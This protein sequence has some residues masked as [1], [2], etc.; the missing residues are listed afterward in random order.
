[1]D[2]VYIQYLTSFYDRLILVSVEK[3]TKVVCSCSKFPLE[4]KFLVDEVYICYLSSFQ[5]RL[6]LVSYNDYTS[7]RSYG[8]CSP[9]VHV[10]LK[11]LYEGGYFINGL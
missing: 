7:Q 9:R 5:D 2:E 11:M 6:I 10:M 1:M 4:S 8:A 3:F